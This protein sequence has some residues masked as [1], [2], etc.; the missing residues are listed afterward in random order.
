MLGWALGVPQ[1]PAVPVGAWDQLS[2]IGAPFFLRRYLQA[3]GT[4]LPFVTRGLWWKDLSQADCRTS[5]GVQG[6]WGVQRHRTCKKDLP[7]TAAW[8]GP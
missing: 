3:Q 5:S 7:S 1:N 2:C 6:L 8:V 4:L